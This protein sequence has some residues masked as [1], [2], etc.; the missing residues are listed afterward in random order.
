MGMQILKLLVSILITILLSSQTVET[1]FPTSIAEK[2]I[3]GF[4]TFLLWTSLEILNYAKS[5][6]ERELQHEEIWS[7]SSEFEVILNN[8][9]KYYHDI[10]K[11]FYGKND[12]FKDYFIE[13]LSSIT[14]TIKNAAEKNELYVQN[15]HFRSTE[16]VLNAF[17]GDD[18]QILRYVWILEHN[19]PFFDDKWKHYCTQIDETIKQN[20]IKQVRALLV[21]S[22]AININ[23]EHV[24][25]LISFYALS[26]GYD[27]RII[28]NKSYTE[29]E[30]DNQIDRKY[31]DFGIY[32]RRYIFRTISY[33]P[34]TGG[35]FSKDQSSIERYTKFFDI[36]WKSHGA[37]QLSK[38]DLKKISLAQLFDIDSK[39]FQTEKE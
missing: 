16:L 28:D 36:A 24:L 30:R 38:R 37:H 12:L 10:S 35:D 39:R 2:V 19:Q 18:S 4:I 27:Y 31:I 14:M 21:Q 20:R 11:H 29:L 34:L 25:A 5:M 13:N 15:Y 9:R 8:L 3:L 23:D 26:E 22:P 7:I 17:E 6:N 33:E 32:G 1:V